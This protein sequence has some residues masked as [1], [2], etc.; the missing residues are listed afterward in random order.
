MAVVLEEPS[1]PKERHLWLTL[2]CQ[3]VER[4]G[5]QELEPQGRAS[6]KSWYQSEGERVSQE[7]NLHSS[8][9]S[10]HPAG[11][12]KNTQLMDGTTLWLCTGFTFQGS[13][14]SIQVLVPP[15][16]SPMTEEWTRD[17]K[18]DI[19]FIKKRKVLPRLRRA[20]EPR[21]KPLNAG[22]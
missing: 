22:S 4:M 9:L 13:C 14:R 11:Q 8:Y 21:K 10:H 19:E 7:E 16:R 18:P 6:L 12:T 5:P 17:T 1:Y 20:N 15:P 3:I 2:G